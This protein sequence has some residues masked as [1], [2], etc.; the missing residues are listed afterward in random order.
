MVITL[1]MTLATQWLQVDIR[2][3]DV[4]VLSKRRDVTI[5]V[6]LLLQYTCGMHSLHSGVQGTRIHGTHVP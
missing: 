5:R 1:M 2:P 6:L 3:T 4:I